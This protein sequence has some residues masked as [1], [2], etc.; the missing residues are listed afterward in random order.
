MFW[1]KHHFAHWVHSL[2]WGN[3]RMEKFHSQTHQWPASFWYWP[4]ADLMHCNLRHSS[5]LP[6]HNYWINVRKNNQLNQFVTLNSNGGERTY[7][8]LDRGVRQVENLHIT[9][10]SRISWNDNAE[11]LQF[12]IFGQ[13][14]LDFIWK[15]ILSVYEFNAPKEIWLCVAP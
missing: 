9:K 3:W 6:L 13:S 14:N 15:L 10:Y 12:I 5:R 7:Q 1:A 4:L 11:D 8:K 2:T